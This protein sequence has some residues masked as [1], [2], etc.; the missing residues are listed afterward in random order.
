[1]VIL[2]NK[3]GALCIAYK[4]GK[5]QLMNHEQDDYPIAFDTLLSIE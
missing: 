4:S 3:G 1:M 2:I 5:I